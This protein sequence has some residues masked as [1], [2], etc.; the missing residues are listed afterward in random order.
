MP[1]K[2]M[3]VSR[4]VTIVCLS[5]MVLIGIGLISYEI[6]GGFPQALQVLLPIIYVALIVLLLR[7][8]V[9]S[10]PDRYQRGLLGGRIHV[11]DIAKSVGC[12]FAAI[13]W[14]AI[15]VRFVTDTPIGAALLLVPAL[16][17]LGT[18]AFF[19]ARGVSRG[20]R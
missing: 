7:T 11:P 15:I 10:I 8:G 18:G 14:V 1:L 13:L 4:P 16:V 9:V 6:R 12:M 2:R 5:I 20:S 3:V 19:F 17:I